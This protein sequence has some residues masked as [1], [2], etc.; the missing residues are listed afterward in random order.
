MAL[1]KQESQNEL[2][3]RGLDHLPGRLLFGR[4]LLPVLLMFFSLLA[5]AP[6]ALAASGDEDFVPNE[7]VV[8][9]GHATDLA[10]VAAQF[11]LDSRPLSQFGSRPIYR[12]KITDGTAVDKKVSQLLADPQLRVVYAEPN[13]LV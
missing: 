10:G 12:L 4:L 9:L 5:S 1:I 8:K 3:G 13:Y 6:K 11:G 2:T 7:V